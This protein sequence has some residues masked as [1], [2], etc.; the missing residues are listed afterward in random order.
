VY[1]CRVDDIWITGNKLIKDF[2]SEIKNKKFVKE[3]EIKIKQKY[4]VYF[5]Y[6]SFKLL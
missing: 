3:N 4:R 1:S 2:L 5:K 6:L